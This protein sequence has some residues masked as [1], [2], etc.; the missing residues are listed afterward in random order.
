MESMGDLALISAISGF[1]PPKVPKLLFR[2]EDEEEE[3]EEEEEEGGGAAVLFHQ[4]GPGLNSSAM[5]ETP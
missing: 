4:F 5:A 2:T 1:Q 3:E